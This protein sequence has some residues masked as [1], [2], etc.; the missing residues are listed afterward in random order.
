L[1]KTMKFFQRSALVHLALAAFAVSA[2]EEQTAEELGYG[3]EV[4]EC[5][6]N[7][8]ELHIDDRQ[9][10]NQGSVLRVCFRPNEKAKEDGVG[11]RRIE[12]FVW[13]MEHADGLAEQYGVKNGRGDDV[14]SMLDCEADGTLCFL[15][16][17][18]G[19]DFYRNRGSVEGVG[20]ATMRIGMGAVPLEK[21]VYQAS[22]KMVFKGDD[23]ETMTPDET[24][25]MMA[26]MDEHNAVAAEMKMDTMSGGEISAEL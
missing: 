11:I 17:L 18:L 9:P 22:F 10:K 14:L 26:K 5:N 20:E 12:F 4:F 23:G 25:E 21:W 24:K 7:L 15:D 16:T 13:Q 1:K 19:T 3:V 2:T 8:E 6:N